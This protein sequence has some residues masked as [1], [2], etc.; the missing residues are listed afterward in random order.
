SGQVGIDLL[1]DTS[2]VG[3]APFHSANDNGDADA[4]GNGLLNAPVLTSARSDGTNL[5][6][7]G[8][9]RPGTSVEL[10][11][12]NADPSGYGEAQS[13]V[14]TLPYLPYPEAFPGSG[15]ALL[16]DG[17]NDQATVPD[18]AALDSI[19][20]TDKVTIEAWVRIQDWNSGWFSVIDKYEATGDFG[21]TMQINSTTGL[22]FI[23]RVG[24]SVSSG[25]VPA[26][27]RWYHL[28][29]SYDRAAGQIQFLAGGQVVYKTSFTGD[30]RDTSGEPLYVGFNPSC[31]DDYSRGMIDELRIWNVAR[32]PAQIQANM[33]QTIAP[34]SGLVGYWRFN[35]G[36]GTTAAD[37]AGASNFTL[38]TS[39]TWTRPTWA[40]TGASV[41]VGSYNIPGVGSDNAATPFTFTIPL[42]AGVG[43]GTLLTATATQNSST[44]EFS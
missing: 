22:E 9:G 43:A 15:T 3:T 17:I 28:A 4:G 34:Q 10:F 23:S 7:T 20:Q 29:V 1:T 18:N 13:Y 30:I 11:A 19:E 38:G 6:L 40:V 12:A 42:P 32:T 25:F 36:S 33:N 27:N 31:G 35:E 8:Y 16:F 37:L 5:T 2:T 26:L 41:P 14:A 21:W 44:S 39:Q 24:Q